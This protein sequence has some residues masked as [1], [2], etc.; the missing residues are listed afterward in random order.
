MHISLLPLT[1]CQYI[2]FYHKYIFFIYYLVALDGFQFVT[3]VSFTVMGKLHLRRNGS[4]LFLLSLSSHSVIFIH[5]LLIHTRTK[6]PM[7]QF[8]AMIIS[9][10]LSHFLFS[11]IIIYQCICLDCPPRAAVRTPTT[12]DPHRTSGQQP[13]SCHH[14]PPVNG[15]QPVFFGTTYLPAVI[16]N[17]GP[18]ASVTQHIASCIGVGL[19]DRPSRESSTYPKQDGALLDADNRVS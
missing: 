18:D 4:A 11:V 3:F 13:L 17:D 7:R 15:L 2:H 19:L 5:K 10:S 16:N 1:A 12:N 6:P 8:A 9:L 14:R